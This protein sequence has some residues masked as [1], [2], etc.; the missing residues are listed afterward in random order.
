MRTWLLLLGKNIKVSLTKPTKNICRIRSFA[1]GTIIK[2]CWK[3]SIANIYSLTSQLFNR[4]FAEP[5]SLT[6]APA[7]QPWACLK[8]LSHMDDDCMSFSGPQFSA[9]Y[10]AIH[11]EYTSEQNWI[12]KLFMAALISKTHIIVTTKEYNENTRCSLCE[13][14]KI[15]ACGYM[16]WIAL[17]HAWHVFQS[18]PWHFCAHCERSE[19]RWE[20]TRLVISILRH[21]DSERVSRTSLVPLCSIQLSSKY[22]KCKV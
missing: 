10:K 1:A 3:Q 20:M 5:L 22:Y 11:T 4:L 21:T 13:Q 7:D 9:V 8:C 14:R 17:L 18:P 15:V 6:C 2:L 12:D 16:M 19:M